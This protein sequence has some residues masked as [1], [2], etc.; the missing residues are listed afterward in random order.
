[1]PVTW[2]KIA[3]EDDVLLITSLVLPFYIEAGTL[4]TIPLTADRKLPFFMIVNLSDPVA[5]NIPLT[6]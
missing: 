2:K 5:N 6:T 1:M 4:D 3:Y